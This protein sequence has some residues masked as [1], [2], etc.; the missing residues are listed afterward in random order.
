MWSDVANV[1]SNL[2][3]WIY[4]LG[5]FVHKRRAVFLKIV[6][7]YWVSEA[8]VGLPVTSRPGAEYKTNKPW[9]T[10]LRLA[11]AVSTLWPRRCFITLVVQPPL[12][13]KC[14]LRWASF[15][16]S[17]ILIYLH[18]W[19]APHTFHGYT[20]D[21][22]WLLLRWWSMV[23]SASCP[24]VGRSFTWINSNNCGRTVSSNR[25]LIASTLDGTPP[26]TPNSHLSNCIDGFASC[27]RP[28]D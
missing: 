11:A 19:T 16:A 8:A 2:Q 24:P 15:I 13:D 25:C 20:Q 22:W 17:F 9:T 6:H 12:H 28:P 10:Q 7:T 21:V 27:H 3:A 4:W 23:D 18:T 1:G 5:F 14:L 26:P